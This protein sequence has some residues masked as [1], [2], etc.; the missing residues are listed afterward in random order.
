MP[1][2]RSFLAVI[3]VFGLL[4]VAAQPAAV[5]D[6]GQP[7]ERVKYAITGVGSALQDT[8]ATLGERWDQ[9]TDVIEEVFDFH[10]A[11]P[12]LP[13]G[14]HQTVSVAQIT[15]S[16]KDGDQSSRLPAELPAIAE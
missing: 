12:L 14:P 11:V 8:E 4:N 5:T 10:Q 13:H 9:I 1:G 16:P 2:I 7:T 15:A 3:L 6:V